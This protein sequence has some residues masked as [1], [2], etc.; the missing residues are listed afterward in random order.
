MKLETLREFVTLVKYQSFTKAA[1]RLYLSQSSLSTHISALEKELGF[2]LVDHSVTPLRLT[3]AGSEFL[4]YAQR[5]LAT[6]TEAKER[7]RGIAQE[8]PPLK[9]QALSTTTELYR[10]LTRLEGVSFTFVDLDTETALFSALETGAIDMETCNDYTGIPALLEQAESKG[11]EFTKLGEGKLSLCMMKDHPLAQ[12][13]S[14]ARRDLD[15]QT[16]VINS[17]A[18]FDDWRQIVAH[19]LGEDIALN[20]HL[21][22][23]GSLCN[24]MATDLGEMVHICGFHIVRQYLAC[25]DDVVVFDAIDGEDITCAEGVAYLASNARAAKLAKALSAEMA[26]SQ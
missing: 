12:R 23:A 9:F 19:L 13:E 25:R 2:D 7:C 26:N 22:P 3:A 8:P 16:V 20:F 24:L 14:L 18:R 4:D 5:I 17:V 15:G 1:R 10:T 6:Y 21:S 11:I